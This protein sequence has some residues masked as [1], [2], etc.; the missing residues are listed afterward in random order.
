MCG[1]SSE[2]NTYATPSTTNPLF[3]GFSRYQNVSFGSQRDSSKQ[4]KEFIQTLESTVFSRVFFMSAFLKIFEKS[5]K[6]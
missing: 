6:F 5:A 1:Q 4:N 3:P 2:Y